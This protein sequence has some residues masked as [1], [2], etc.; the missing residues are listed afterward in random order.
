VC[1]VSDTSAP[2]RMGAALTYARRYALFTLVGIAGEDDLDAPDP[3]AVKLN[4]G[5]PADPTESPPAQMNGH[6]S[7]PGTR[8]TNRSRRKPLSQPPKP[9]LAAEPSAALRKQLTVEMANVASADDMVGWALRTLPIKNTLTP[10]DASII[11]QSFQAKINA[12]APICD[13]GLQAE[14]EPLL[15]VAPR[16]GP[17]N[18]PAEVNIGGNNEPPSVIDRKGVEAGQLKVPLAPK[19][20][21][22]ADTPQG[23]S[24]N[25]G[26]INKSVLPIGRPKR[27]RDKAHLIFVATQACLLCGRQ[28][29][30]AH[31]L[32][33][34][35]P[36]AIGMKVGDEFTV[37]LC[38]IHHRQVHQT[39]KEAEWWNDLDI[40][41]VEIAKGLWE[42]S[43]A[44]RHCAAE[45]TST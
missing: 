17:I 39:G 29:S 41:A 13:S 27:R 19:Q 2:H 37:P 26:Q 33:F 22:Q 32:R 42:Q 1:P 31:H 40:D 8:S 16:D 18:V 9:I 4:G 28:P 10:A 23:K 12:F 38:R 44:K 6:P 34:A 30:D 25:A 3:P 45:Q 11:E 14:D 15:P 24:E 36:R 21:L 43:M 20:G 35:Q 5:A 7:G